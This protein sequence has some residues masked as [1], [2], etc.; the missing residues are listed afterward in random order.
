MYALIT[1][2]FNSTVTVQREAQTKNP[3]GGIS[4]TYST[5]IASLPCRIDNMDIR[6]RTAFVEAAGLGKMTVIQ[7]LILYCE[8]S[9]ANKAITESDRVVLGTRTFQVKGINNPGLLD[10]HLAIDLLEVV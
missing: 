3:M 1:D 4:R 2:F 10:R 6:R 5:R 8:A 9:S 7:G